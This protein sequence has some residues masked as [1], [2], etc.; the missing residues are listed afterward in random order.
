[1]KTQNELKAI[2]AV[3][4]ND[5]ALLESRREALSDKL[6][7]VRA[8]IFRIEHGWG[9]GSEVEILGYRCV[10][11]ECGGVF[12]VADYVGDTYDLLGA[13]EFT[14]FCNGYQIHDVSAVKVLKP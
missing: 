11:V 1:M 7:A 12:P 2:E 6:T 5:L 13:V 4:L 3:L 9:V 8:D 14:L 10:I